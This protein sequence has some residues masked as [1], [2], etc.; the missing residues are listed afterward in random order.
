[1][2]NNMQN[3]VNSLFEFSSI[4]SLRALGQR[5]WRPK[6][7]KRDLSLKKGGALRKPGIDRNLFGQFGRWTFWPFLVLDILAGSGPNAIRI[8]NGKFR[9]WG[10]FDR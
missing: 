1:M 7:R 3:G 10:N 9:R 2:V 5:L 6:P 4:R 8:N